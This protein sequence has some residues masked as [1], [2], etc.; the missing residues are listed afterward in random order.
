MGILLGAG[1]A[2]V[3]TVNFIGT[4]HGYATTCRSKDFGCT[5]PER[6]VFLG[7]SDTDDYIFVSPR[8]VVRD[9]E[10]LASSARRRLSESYTGAS[11]TAEDMPTTMDGAFANVQTR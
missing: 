9:A 2:T 3:T 11:T 4:L 6:A 5:S 10:A 8:V 7:T 1:V